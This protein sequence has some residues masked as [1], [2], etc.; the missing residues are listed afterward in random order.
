[1]SQCLG[2]RGDPVP[3]PAGGPVQALEKWTLRG[4]TNPNR[5]PPEWNV[6]PKVTIHGNLY[7][8]CLNEWPGNGSNG[9]FVDGPLN[10]AA[11]LSRLKS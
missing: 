9:R 5:N 10:S 1:M 2:K 8:G 3:P 4:A 11:S 7:V 6:S